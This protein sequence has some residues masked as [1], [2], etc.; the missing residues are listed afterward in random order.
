MAK[1]CICLTG[2]TL[3][4][5]LEVLE[6][7]RKY[8]DLAELRVDCLEPDERFLIRRFP[9]MAGLPVILTIRRGLEG[10]YFEGGEGSRI[11]L[12]AKG[13]ANAEAD[14]RRNFA[15]VDLEDDL[16]VPSLEEATRTFGTRIIRSWHNMEGVDENLT[17][18]IRKL[19]RV[20]DELV[21]VAVMPASLDDV[22]RVYRAAKETSDVDKILHC[23]GDYGVNTRI[24]SEFLGS[25]ISY[26]SPLSE[27]GLPPAA[28]GQLDPKELAEFYRFREITTKT[29]VLASAGFPLKVTTSPFFFNTVFRMEQTD[30]VFIPIV[31]DSV[32]SLLRLAEEIGISGISITVPYKEEILPYLAYKSQ[33]V[34]SI[35]ACNTI[36]AGP[37]GWMGYN[38]DA[39]GFSDSLL[40]Y[41]GKK[42]LRGRK[43]TIVGAG[44]AAKAV[45]SEV[46]RL[47]GKA[48]IL[49]RTP[50]RA[51]SLAEPYR[52]AW[53]GFDSR[54]AVLMEKYSAIIIQASSLGMA[55]N[56]GE[57]PIE[58]YKFSGKEIVMDLIYEPKKTPCLKRAEQAGCRVL[59]G[60]DMLHR[61]VRYQY[62]YYMNKEF[63]PSL[64]SRVQF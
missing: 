7:N 25:R 17:A 38:T 62:A 27:I 55:P 30:A 45:A 24:L 36:V 1:I 2:K 48:L 34:L 40:S 50:A 51:R 60:I 22:V 13:L 61:Q 6:R 42:D 9:E 44:G 26:V 28:P 29:K 39:A 3:A 31:A 33:E 43:I 41:I 5:D 15:Y 19:R 57:D 52:F 54:G 23:M 18:K 21:K 46:Y 59:G 58:F 8:V 4:Q 14:R 63:P 35:G 20:G 53:A 49:N 56:T 11:G 32:Q 37:E 16:D 12:L 64:V 10:G 47:K